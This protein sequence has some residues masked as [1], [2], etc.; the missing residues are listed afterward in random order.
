[1]KMY[2]QPH[3]AYRSLNSDHTAAC[4]DRRNLQSVTKR[5]ATI[6]ALD[7]SAALD[8]INQS[9]YIDATTAMGF[10]S[11]QVRYSHAGS[12]LERGAICQIRSASFGPFGPD[13]V[14][15]HVDRSVLGRIL[16]ELC[17]RDS[18]VGD[19][20]GLRSWDPST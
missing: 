1:M 5:P 19:A 9:L 4:F 20:R 13:S 7:K 8:T 2:G 12:G 17:V 11:P 3:I 16:S 10:L 14:V 18:I 6:V 15:R